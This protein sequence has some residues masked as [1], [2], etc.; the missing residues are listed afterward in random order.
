M[1]TLQPATTN[2][3]DTIRQLAWNIFPATYREILSPG[4]ITY[5]MEWM[6]SEASLRTQMEEEGHTY[7]LARDGDEAIGYV[8]VQ[9]ENDQLWCLQKIYVLPERQGQHVGSFLFDHAIQFIRDHSTGPCAMELHVN[10][11]NK[12]LTFYQS[13]GMVIDSEGDFPIGQG[14]EMNDYIMRMEIR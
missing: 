8:S 9:P 10:R 2:D 5:M 6:Y 3:I 1:L 12:A 4:Q 7:L 11:E 13:K 14:Y